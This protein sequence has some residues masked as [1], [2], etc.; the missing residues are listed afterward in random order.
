MEKRNLINWKVSRLKKETS[1]R[2]NAKHPPTQT[3][4]EPIGKPGMKHQNKKIEK[5]G[6]VCDKP[7]TTK[8][9]SLKLNF[10]FLKIF[11]FTLGWLHVCMFVCK[12]VMWREK[13]MKSARKRNSRKLSKFVLLRKSLWSLRYRFEGF[14][15][16]CF[17]PNR[18]M[19]RICIAKSWKLEINCLNIL[20]C[21]AILP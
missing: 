4:W 3:A 12:N 7:W 8:E 19:E 9:F 1:W 14:S 15:C 11:F 6:K 18:S 2:K 5:I 21:T 17:G 13:L 10:N 16:K 20:F